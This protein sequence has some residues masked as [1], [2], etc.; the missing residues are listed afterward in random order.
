MSDRVKR[1]RE[2]LQHLA[3]EYLNTEANR[4]SLITVTSALISRDFKNAT[5][6]VTV[7]PE[8]DEEAVI[9]YLKRKRSDF[10]AYVSKHAHMKT[11]PFFE[12]EI[13]EGEKN[14]QK[15]DKLLSD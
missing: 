12:F 9:N 3:A 10:R 4:L 14:R 7:Y 11:M 2:Q 8:E 13:D 15:I 5:I 1:V 6:F